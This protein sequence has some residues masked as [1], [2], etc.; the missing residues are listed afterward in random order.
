LAGGDG[1]PDAMLAA[2]REAELCAALELSGR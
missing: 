2:E 1:G